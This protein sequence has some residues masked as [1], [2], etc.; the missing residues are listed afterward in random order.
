MRIYQDFK[1]AIPEIK[2]DLVEMGIKIHPKTYQDKYI[3]DDPNFETLELQNYIYSVVNPMLA[4]LD[5]VQPW[6][7]MEWEERKMGI[8]GLPVNPGSAWHLRAE[9]WSEFI[10]PN[11]KFA[12]TYSHRLSRYQQ[13][14]TIIKRIK[15][16]PDSRQLFIAI[17]DSADTRKLGGISR[18]PCSLGYQ[19]Q[20]RKEQLN[21]TYLQRSADLATHF[22]N[23]IYLAVVLQD[24][25]AKSTG[26]N[27][28]YFT[29][30]LGSLHMFR[31]DSE[32]VF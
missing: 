31:K 29:H 15:D 23:D 11:Q 24:F 4:E 17:W 5:A 8:E 7:D 27:R 18:V 1:E 16:D 20:I 21:L 13:V 22:V 26:Y 32:G 30:W 6:A 2:R 25:L 9:V 14:Q 19:I 12:Y 10:Q 3:A 28:G